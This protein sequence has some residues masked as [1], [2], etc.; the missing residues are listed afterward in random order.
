M[1]AEQA[2]RAVEEALAGRGLAGSVDLV[3][4]SRTF[5]VSFTTGRTSGPAVASLLTA[6]GLETAISVSGPRGAVFGRLAG[7]LLPDP[8]IRGADSGHAAE[9]ASVVPSKACATC[10]AVLPAGDFSWWNKPLGKRSP[11]CPACNVARIRASRA[12][13]RA[14]SSG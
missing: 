8:P 11:Y 13:A 3:E 9:S 5:I 2:V 14:V 4:C 12:A 1:N 6:M 7:K 10:K